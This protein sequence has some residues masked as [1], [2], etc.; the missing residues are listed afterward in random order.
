MLL[1]VASAPLALFAADAPGERIRTETPR[2]V[3]EF[4]KGALTAAEAAA[5]TELADRGV[6][7]V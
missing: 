4:E 1:V 7:D 5:F 3:I 6:A 2:V